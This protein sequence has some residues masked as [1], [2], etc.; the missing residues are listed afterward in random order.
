M[1]TIYHLLDVPAEKKEELLK[2]LT[3]PDGFAGWWTAKTVQPEPDILRFHFPGDYHKDFRA[4]IQNDDHIEYECI[5]A[6][7]EWVGTTISFKLMEDN[8]R[9]IVNFRHG[10]WKD[11]T[12]MYGICNYHWALYMKSL[13]DL[14]EKG[15]G[16][17]TIVE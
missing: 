13:K 5:D 6:H 8:G 17:P 10:G 3:T 14:V 16:N 12:P 7:P 9:I 1:E 4:S 11:Q 15:K 2:A